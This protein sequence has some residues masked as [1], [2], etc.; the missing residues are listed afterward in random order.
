MA[1]ELKPESLWEN[2]RFQVNSGWDRSNYFALVETGALAGAWHV[3][4]DPKSLKAGLFFAFLGLLFTILWFVN[5]WINHTYILYWWRS[6]SHAKDY[7]A[8][9]GQ[10]GIRRWWGKVGLKYSHLMRLIPILFGIAWLWLLRS[11]LPSPRSDYILA[12]VVGLLILW[13]L[14]FISKKISDCAESRWLQSQRTT[15]PC[16]GPPN[17]PAQSLPTCHGS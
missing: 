13:L 16:Q 12:M 8:N 2:W 10:L 1:N 6:T 9:A 5:D 14:L 7:D 17:H 11:Y 15:A 4:Q 3:L